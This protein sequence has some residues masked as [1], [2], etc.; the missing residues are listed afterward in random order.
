[1][2]CRQRWDPFWIYVVLGAGASVVPSAVTV[3]R[4][5]SLRSIGLPVFLVTLA[6]PAIAFLTERSSSFVWRAAA[7]ALI[8]AAAAQFAVFQ[9]YYWRDGPKRLDAFHAAFPHVFS[10]AAATRLP[11]VIYLYDYE[12]LGQ[13]QW[14]GRL[15]RIPVR[16]VA[17]EQAAPR[18]SVVVANLSSCP[19]CRIL[20]RGGIFTAYVTG[21]RPG[22]RQHRDERGVWARSLCPQACPMIL[23]HALGV[24]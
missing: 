17:T 13:G 11:V 3:E 18:R 8:A 16:F 2:I 14:Y 23:A 6:I 24:A 10:A 1:V 15:W 12:A 5:H 4:I 7:I 20:S 9:L 19:T 21:R 22:A